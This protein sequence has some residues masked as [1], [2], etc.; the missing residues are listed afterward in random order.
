MKEQSMIHCK[1]TYMENLHFIID[2]RPY[3][4][5][6]PVIFWLERITGDAFNLDNLPQWRSGYVI[7]YGF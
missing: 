4:K 6:Q 5:S 2:L 1:V 3:N 7:G